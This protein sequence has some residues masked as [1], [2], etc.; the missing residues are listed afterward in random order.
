MKTRI[1]ARRRRLRFAVLAACLATTGTAYAATT[2]AAQDSNSGGVS[3]A[4]AGGKSKDRYG[5]AVRLSGRV[6][7]GSNRGVSLEHAPRGRGWRPVA[8]ST[9]A[10]DGGYRFTVRARQ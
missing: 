1:F 4:S 8:R 10:A 9:S 3:I 2:P 5:Q 6:A 7:T